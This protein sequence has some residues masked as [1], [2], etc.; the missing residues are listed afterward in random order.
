M[1]FFETRL[2][3]ALANFLLCT[4]IGWCCICRFHHMSAD[5]TRRS[6]RIAFSLLFAGAS[7]SGFSPVLFAHFPGPGHVA[8]A[9]GI[10]AV[11]IAGASEWRHGLP[12]YARTA[13]APL[14]AIPH[15]E[16][17]R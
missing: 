13:P 8:L 9:I 4:G 2:L 7:A 16:S 15:Y 3:L 17:P 12:E 5:T 1:N 11:L 6:V 10:L 14:D